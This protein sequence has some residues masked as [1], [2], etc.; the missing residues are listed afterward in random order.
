M[1]VGHGGRHGRRARG[2]EGGLLW[3]LG[4]LLIGLTAVLFGIFLAL[5]F[6]LVFPALATQAPRC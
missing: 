3:F 6:A 4:V 2:R 1:A 5:T